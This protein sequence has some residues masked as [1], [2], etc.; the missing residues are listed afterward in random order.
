MIYQIAFVAAVALWILVIV[1]RRQVLREDRRVADEGFAE[2]RA[3]FAA[4]ERTLEE[5]EADA[6]FWARVEVCELCA[7]G[8]QMCSAHYSRY[9]GR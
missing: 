2:M 5:L 6:E 3:G 4:D 8:R 1:A 7:A 9:T